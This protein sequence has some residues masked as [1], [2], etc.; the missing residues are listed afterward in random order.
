MTRLVEIEERLSAIKG[1]LDAPDANLE[2]LETEIR[3]LQE[4]RDGLKAQA[5]KR[6]AL[7]DSI[8]LGDGASVIKT[9]KEE[10]KVDLMDREA[11]VASPEYRNAF[12]KNLLGKELT[13]EERTYITSSTTSSGAAIPFPTAEMLFEKMIK[14]APMLSEITLLRIAGNV[15]FSAEST[16]DAAALHTQNAADTPA[17]DA[18][19]TVSLTGYEFTKVLRVSKTVAVMG[20]NAFEGWLTDMLAEDIARII[21]HYI[22]NGSGSSQPQGVAYAHA[23]WTTTYEISTTASITYDNVQ[24]LIALLPAGYDG[25]AK[26]LCNKKFVYGSLAKIA[27][28]TTNAPILVKDMEAGLRF[29]LMGF[30]IIISDKVADDTMYF[31]DYKKIVGNLPQEIQVDRSLESGFLSN[32]VDFRGSAI[33]DCKVG[34]SDAFVKFK[35]N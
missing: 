7:V 15:N 3:T 16:R 35:K 11:L 23:T 19:I 14:L 26:F 28:A 2:T 5:E 34:N 6:K 20:I 24:D 25:N 9:F 33:F 13:V 22:I 30:P 1:E 21:E 8:V 27:E 4:E 12:L 18:I 17:S 31:G 29:R 32:A 10:R